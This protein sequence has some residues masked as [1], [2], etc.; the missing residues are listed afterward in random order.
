MTPPLAQPPSA[1]RRPVRAVSVASLS[2]KPPETD[3]PTFEFTDPAGLLV[4]ET[5]QRNLSERSLKLIRKII[6]GWDWRR[7]KPPVVART[8]GGFEVIDGQHTAIAAASHPDVGLIP[9]MVVDAADHAKRAQAFIGH[10]RDR[11]GVT[12]MQLHFAASAGGD[13]EAQTIDQVCARAG[14]AI[15]KS[16]PGNGVWK[17]RQTV[18]IN[19]IAALINRR[20]AAGARAVLQVLADANLAPILASHVKAVELLLF[21]PEYKGAIEGPDITTALMA[22]GETAEQEAGVFAATHN[23]QKWRALA[24]VLFK[25]GKKRG[26]R[27]AD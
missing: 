14:V 2:P 19:A 5:Y 16:T 9:V 23:V 12:A 6:D 1:G 11:L 24:I 3:P 27:S 4:D 18:A 15:L 21:G 20:H 10:N 17:P 13:E 7:F 22:L 26:R 25:R 8:E